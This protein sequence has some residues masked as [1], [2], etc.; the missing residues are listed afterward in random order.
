MTVV[1]WLVT[2][3]WSKIESGLQITEQLSL[4]VPGEINASIILPQ[5]IVKT[6]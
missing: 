2:T 5:T 1:N 6:K 3:L 4:S